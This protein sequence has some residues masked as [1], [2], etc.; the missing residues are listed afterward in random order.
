M[1]GSN[2]YLYQVCFIY[3][4]ITLKGFF[5]STVYNELLDLDSVLLHVLTYGSHHQAGIYY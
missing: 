1:L 3:Q 2:H 5:M 4:N